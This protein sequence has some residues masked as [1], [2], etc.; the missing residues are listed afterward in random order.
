MLNT[1][2]CSI[3]G[4]T[5]AYTDY[6][7]TKPCTCMVDRLNDHTCPICHR[8]LRRGQNGKY[9]PCV[10]Q[11]A[12]L[13]Q[14]FSYGVPSWY[15]KKGDVKRE[16][17]WKEMEYLTKFHTKVPQALVQKILDDILDKEKSKAKNSEPSHEAP[18]L[19][20]D[21]KPRKLIPLK[22]GE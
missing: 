7:R 22:R 4:K 10:C 8:E 11:E 12:T 16:I 19:D 18:S 3:C 1:N 15:V 9:L 13:Y 17:P 20:V 2:R 21:V 5:L 14:D 6:G